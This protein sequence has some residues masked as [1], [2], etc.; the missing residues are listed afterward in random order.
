MSVKSIYYLLALNSYFIVCSPKMHLGSLYPS[1]DSRHDTELCQQGHWGHDQ[2]TGFPSWFAPLPPAAPCSEQ[3][4]DLLLSLLP[5][6]GSFVIE[7]FCWDTSLWMAFPG[8][9]RGRFLANSASVAVQQF[10][11]YCVNW[12]MPSPTRSRFQPFSGEPL[13]WTSSSAL[14]TVA[15]PYTCFVFRVLTSY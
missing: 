13:P 2:K 15:A 9:L 5:P 8:A 14:R 11:C 3:P 10:L 4:Q 6:W 12:T 1:F 7:S